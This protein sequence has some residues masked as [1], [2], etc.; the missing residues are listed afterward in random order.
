MSQP[1]NDQSAN[2]GVHAESS[3]LFGRK[4]P[5]PIYTVVFFLL[6][7]LTIVEVVLSEVLSGVETLKIAVL[8]GIAAA[9]ATLVVI[10]YM[11]LNHD[12]R[13]FAV[14]FIVPVGI[15]LLSLLFLL[16]ATS[17]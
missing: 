9:K 12:S 8:L 4:F 2:E 5:F 6:A 15:S 16:G 13:F 11:H 10:F 3:Q 7:I 14:A 17:V 1:T